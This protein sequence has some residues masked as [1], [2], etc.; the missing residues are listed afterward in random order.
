MSE[1][2]S[3]IVALSS[4]IIKV[5]PD[6]L[7][8]KIAAGEVVQRPASVLKELVENAVDAG[9]TQIKIIIKNAGRELVHVIDDGSGMSAPDAKLCFVRHA[10]SKISRSE[11]LHN[12]RT[13]GFRGEAMASIAAVAQVVLKTKRHEDE[14]GTMVSVDGSADLSFEPIATPSGTSVAVNNLFFNVP[15]RRNFLKSNATE[16]KHLTEVFQQIALAHPEIGFIFVHDELPVYSFSPRED[17]AF[18]DRLEGRIV[19]LFGESFKARLVPVDQ[20]IQ[21]LHMRGFVSKAEFSR[22]TRGDQYLFINDRYVKSRSLDHAVSNAYGEILPSRSFPF[23]ALFIYLDPEHVDVNVHPTKAEVKFDDERGIYGFMYARIKKALGE[24]NLIPEIG[25][26]LKG[27]MGELPRSNFAQRQSHSS[28]QPVINPQYNFQSA[29]G[30]R[31]AFKADGLELAKRILARQNDS[32]EYSETSTGHSR[33]EDEPI[34]ASKRLL[35]QLLK[36]YI[37]V[38]VDEGTMIIDQHAAHERILYEKALKAFQGEKWL[39]QKMLFPMTLEYDPVDLK[40][41]EELKSELTILGFELESFGGRT[42]AV[43]GEPVGVAARSNRSLLDEVLDRYKSYKDTS[44]TAVRDNLAKSLSCR[45]AIKTGK[46]LNT[47]EIQ[48]LIDDLFACDMPYACPH[49]RPTMIKI[50]IDE[51]DRRFGRVGHL[52]R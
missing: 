18:H 28:F 32:Q 3:G 42:L 27:K 2:S 25:F 10:T 23:F 36:K 33:P 47:T 13:L 29:P 30:Q 1:E 40:L 6:D 37:L 8:N 41:I 44:N 52:E 17:D 21:S 15:A 11:D 38:E 43:H 50:S 45:S 24:A 5:L 7:A 39:T 16:Y 46:V 22:R 12:I 19:D 26:D 48:V 34:A 51:L 35:W 20:S 9:A 31:D 14:L 4:G 49:G